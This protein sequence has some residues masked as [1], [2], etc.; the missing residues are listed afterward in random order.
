MF[1]TCHAIQSPIVK[2]HRL[3]I[4]W[5]CQR[6]FV[7]VAEIVREAAYTWD[8][9]GVERFVPAHDFEED[10]HIVGGCRV[11]TGPGC[12]FEC[13]GCYAHT[14]AYETLPEGPD[15]YPTEEAER[16]CHVLS[17]TIGHSSRCP[18]PDGVAATEAEYAAR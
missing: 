1:R 5:E 13:P 3:T 15:G 10:Y 4:G 8:E 9:D 14:S 16:D 17:M 6:P 2:G 12:E 7:K 18:Y 11:F